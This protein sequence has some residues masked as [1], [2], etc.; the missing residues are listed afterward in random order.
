GTAD[1]A[2]ELRDIPDPVAAGQN[3]TYSMVIGNSGPGL[4]SNLSWN[5]TVPAGTAFQSMTT[6]AGWT[7]PT[8]PTLGGTGPFMCTA[9][10]LA[11]STWAEFVIT[12]Q[13]APGTAPGMVVSNTAS[14]SSGTPDPTTV[15]NS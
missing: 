4:A 11:A 5:G 14:I 12:V 1:L 8:A 3:L 7:C 15:N 2:I 10:S 13:V 6:P 9:V